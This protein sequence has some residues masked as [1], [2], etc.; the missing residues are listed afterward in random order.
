LVMSG[1]LHAPGSPWLQ[2]VQRRRYT[3]PVA[4]IRLSSAFKGPLAPNVDDQEGSAGGRVN[5]K[6]L[7]VIARANVNQDVFRTSILNERS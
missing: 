4:R 6:R 3:P 7:C 1:R 2:T 5:E